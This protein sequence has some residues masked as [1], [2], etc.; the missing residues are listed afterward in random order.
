MSNEKKAAEKP[1]LTPEQEQKLKEQKARKLAN[2]K[3]LKELHRKEAQERDAKAKVLLDYLKQKGLYDQL[4]DEL[5]EFVTKLATPTPV[6]NTVSVFSI[7]FGD[8][9]QVGQKITLMEAFKKT[10]K[11]KANIDHFV[12]KKWKEAGIIVEYTPNAESL[13]DGVYEIK[14]LPNA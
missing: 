11:G 5:K 8:N 3:R 7:L 2:D 4:T 6:H 9:P 13:L 10:A 14:A 1:A 12:N